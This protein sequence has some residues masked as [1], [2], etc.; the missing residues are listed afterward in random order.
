MS[1]LLKAFLLR[2]V[3]G[4]TVGGLF[5]V[6]LLLLVPLAGVLKFIGLPILLVLGTI[7]APLF[8]V[9]GAIGLPMLLVVGIG[10]G[11][12]LLVGGMLAIGILAI[13]IV[14]PILL[15]VWL[16]RWLRRPRETAAE[17]GPVMDM[18]PGASS[19]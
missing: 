12:L 8:L 2:F 7:G 16:V 17:A 5:G 18:E 15:A 4:R 19:L 14:L 13:K 10:G 1:L 9:L 11:L 3:V 6:L